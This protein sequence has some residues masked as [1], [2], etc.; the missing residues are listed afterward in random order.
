MIRLAYPA[1]ILAALAMA[2]CTTSYDAP[3]SAAGAKPSVAV[4]PAVRAGIIEAISLTSL[5][6]AA[7]A[8]GTLP[9]VT[10]GPYR[11]ALR[12]D[13]GTVQIIQTYSRAFLV[14]DRVQI[15]PDGK[16]NRP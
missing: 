13:D 1:S 11:V 3:S 10:S 7:S 2:G 9:A 12:M 16:L 15:M 8:G 5:P 14:G 4:A 6:T